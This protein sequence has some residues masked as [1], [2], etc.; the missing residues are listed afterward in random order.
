MQEG[1]SYIK[2]TCDFLSKSKNLKAI[3]ENAI[4]V[5]A[6][7]V[8]LYSSIPHQAGLEALGEALY[9]RKSHKIPTEKLVKMAKFVLKN[10]F[11]EFSD[12]VYQHITETAMTKFPPPYACIF[13][14]HVE[15]QF[16]PTQRLQPLI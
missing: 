12:K 3:P 7:V 15:N 2:D 13:I 11:F 8:G 1:K 4:L 16:L 14:N 10:I 6:E 9:K 5:T